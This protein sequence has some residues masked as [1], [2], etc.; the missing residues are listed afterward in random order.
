V[1]G[2]RDTTPIEGPVNLILST[3]I[4]KDYANVI[5]FALAAKVSEKKTELFATGTGEQIISYLNAK[6]A[7]HHAE[8]KPKIGRII[9]QTMSGAMPHGSALDALQEL[10]I[11]PKYRFT[12]N[13]PVD[14]LLARNIDIAD[15]IAGSMLRRSEK[16]PL[17]AAYD[18]LLSEIINNPAYAGLGSK[19]NMDSALGYL[20]SKGADYDVAAKKAARSTTPN[21]AM[22]LLKHLETQAGKY[23]DG[24][25]A[26]MIAARD[27]KYFTVGSLLRQLESAIPNV[28]ECKEELN[29]PTTGQTTGLTSIMYA[30]R[31]GHSDIVNMLAAHGADVNAADAQGV[32]PLMSATIRK[33]SYAAELLKKATED[34]GKRGDKD[35]VLTPEQTEQVVRLSNI[36]GYES[37][38]GQGAITQFGGLEEIGAFTL[39]NTM[40]TEHKKRAEPKALEQAAT[41]PPEIIIQDNDILTTPKAQLEELGRLT[42]VEAKLIE[43]GAKSLSEEQQKICDA[44]V[45]AELEGKRGFAGEHGSLRGSHAKTGVGRG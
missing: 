37:R 40:H 32:T 17:K 36:K 41:K 30:T 6:I 8:L 28:N 11:D 43:H 5:E 1:P 22:P 31:S 25:T 18:I 44:T 34:K 19:T 42:L 16:T 26:L 13:P 9:S 7:L 38:F 33:E 45:Q 24:E 2:N 39:Y 3:N 21:A 14:Q 29:K 35:I 4:P 10:G 27:G 23:G 20:L 12:G 15:A